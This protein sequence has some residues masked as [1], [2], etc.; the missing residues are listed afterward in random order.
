[1]KRT[2]GNQ[3]W[4]L[5]K[6]YSDPQVCHKICS[7]VICHYC[8]FFV[9]TILLLQ[10]FLFNATAVA[11]TFAATLPPFLLALLLLSLN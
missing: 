4:R 9:Y 7:L 3:N 10:V 11:I 6:D 1:M 8:C 2:P 5:P